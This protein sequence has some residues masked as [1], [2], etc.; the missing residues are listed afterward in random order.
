MAHSLL[1]VLGGFAAMALLVMVT[2]ALAAVLLVPGGMMAMSQPGATLPRAYLT[3]NVLCS[4][5]AA[6]VGG[7]ITA[8]LAAADPLWHGVALAVLMV[9][10]SVGSM[11]QARGR[12]PRWYQ[13]TLMTAMP[14]LAILGGWLGTLWWRPA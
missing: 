4:A 8:R 2:T 5:L 14:A 6:L 3:V 7:G 11:R 9:L 10:M 12:Q 13:F 1:A